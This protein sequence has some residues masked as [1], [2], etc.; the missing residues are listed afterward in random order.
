[1]QVTLSEVGAYTAIPFIN[2]GKQV[3]HHSQIIGWSNYISPKR[4]PRRTFIRHL[5][6]M[7]SHRRYHSISGPETAGHPPRSP[8]KRYTVVRKSALCIS[9]EANE[10]L[11]TDLPKVPQTANILCRETESTDRMTYLPP[12][13]PVTARGP[14]LG[15]QAAV[16]SY[17][18]RQASFGKNEAS[19]PSSVVSL[20]TVP[21]MKLPPLPESD[22]SRSQRRRFTL[23]GPPP[24]LAIPTFTA[25]S[26][27]QLVQWKLKREGAAK[28]KEM[29]EIQKV[30]VEN[31][32][33]EERVKP[34]ESPSNVQRSPI[35]ARVAC[36]RQ[37]LN[38]LEKRRNSISFVVS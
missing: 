33:V 10:N 7:S 20:P 34:F 36:G 31:P 38:A 17:R 30:E 15:L 11:E 3:F 32:K 9:I 12:K 29:V 22:L 16:G 5:F 8:A 2:I 14:S 26:L 27:D 13:S 18:S 4:A 23:S 25:P 28:V 6:D 21:A 35:S 19:P 37:M 1:M 24:N